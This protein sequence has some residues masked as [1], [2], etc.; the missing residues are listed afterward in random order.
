MFVYDASFD[1][2]FQM[3]LYLSGSFSWALQSLGVLQVHGADGAHDLGLDD[4]SVFAVPDIDLPGFATD[5]VAQ[6]LALSKQLI[7]DDFDVR[8]SPCSIGGFPRFMC[9]DR[10]KHM[11]ERTR[12]KTPR[13]IRVNRSRLSPDLRFCL[14]GSTAS[15]R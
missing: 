3:S 11:I 9:A 14:S 12:S 1:P 15:W 6:K 7:S 13:N 4:D 10:M 2:R 5:D 8:S